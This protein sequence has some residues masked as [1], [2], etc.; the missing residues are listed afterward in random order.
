MRPGWSNIK[1]IPRIKTHMGW[2]LVV[3]AWGACPPLKVP[4]SKPPNVATSGVGPT[5]VKHNT[6]NPNF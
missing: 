4:G 1:A 3:K 6:H 5:T 2:P